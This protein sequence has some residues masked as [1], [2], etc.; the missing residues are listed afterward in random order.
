MGVYLP[1]P[2]TEKKVDTG[3]QHHRFA[4]A[5]GSMQGWRTTMEDAHV[6]VLD[7]EQ[8]ASLFCV[9]D[10]HGGAQVAEFCAENFANLLVNKKSYKS[11]DYKTAL[12]KTFLK[13]DKLLLKKNSEPDSKFDAFSTGATAVAA[14]IKQNTLYVANSGDSRCVLSRN[15]I[16]KPMSFDHKPGDTIEYERIV[17]AGGYVSQGRVNSNLNLSRALGDLEYKQNAN[18][19][20]SEQ[21]IS[22]FP[23]IEITELTNADD[24]LLL[25]CD[26]IWDVFRNQQ[27][28]DFVGAKLN[29]I[30]S[31]N[32]S[33][34]LSIINAEHLKTVCEEMLDSCLGADSNS[35]GPGWDNMTFIVVLLKR[36]GTLSQKSEAINPNLN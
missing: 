36:N 20:P 34:N 35:P 32:P 11:G 28:I 1:K 18:L 6:A 5:A 2:K 13:I 29:N 33:N 26:G 27:A 15:L 9:F 12:E 4:F 25:G 8:D 22:G 7:L 21:I 10:G 3:D 16:E 24:F 30:L 14:L 23:D 31:T 17:K 19:L